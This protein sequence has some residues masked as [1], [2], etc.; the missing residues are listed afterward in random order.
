M[1]KIRILWTDDEI[2]DLKSHIFFLTEKGYDIDTCSNGTDTIELIKKNNYDLLFLDENMPGLSGLETL[3]II[4]EIR[5]EIPIIMIT[6]SEAEE[7]MDSAIGSAIAD[8]LI[9]PVKPNQILLAIKK[10]LDQKRLVTEKTTSGYQQEFGRIDNMISN[11][12]T[13]NDWTELFKKLVFWET[14]LEK[15][16]DPG[17]NEILNTQEA[18]ANNA[19][20]K[21]ISANYLNWFGNDTV[22]K[23]LLSPALMSRK[24]FPEVKD[25]RPVFFILIDNLRFDQWKTISAEL[26]EFYRTIEEELYLS[27]LP[28]ATQYSRNAIFAGLMPSAIYESMPEY[29]KNDDDEEGKNQFEEKLLDRQISR[30]GLKYIW[31]YDKIGSNLEGKKVIAKMKTLLKNDLNVLVYNFVDMLSHARTDIGLIRDL[32]NDERAYRSLTR[33][34]FL[35]SSLFDLLKLLSKQKIK[36]ILTTDHGT[37]RV[38]NPV[39][40]LGDRQTSSNLR[41]KTGKNLDY[42]SGSVFEIKNPEKAHLP[43]V[44]LSSRYIFA[45]NKDFLVYPNNYN[46]F[47]NYFKDTFQHGG[48]SM[49]E[50]MIPIITLEPLS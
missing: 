5:P 25:K 48:V 37:I 20:S 1:R 22:E 26:S 28:T 43:K 44:N 18:E 11:A 47:A 6:K 14:E 38:Q 36:I 19:F 45:T 34:W 33:S 35:H 8:Y 30:N 46:Y 29:W 2:E 16:T 21:Y 32:A 23:P 17:M 4:K 27:I 12:R 3:K 24:V 10:N 40:V 15:S 13:F 49:H 42:D 7:I 9:K 41:Y 31:T 50:M 39:K